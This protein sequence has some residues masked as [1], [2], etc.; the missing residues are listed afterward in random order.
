MASNEYPKAPGPDPNLDKFTEELAQAIGAAGVD[1]SEYDEW[2]EEQAKRLQEAQKDLFPGQKP[3]P[4]PKL[5]PDGSIASE[6]HAVGAGVDA[7]AALPK[8][9]VKKRKRK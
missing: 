5:N 2:R 4:L 8:K 6:S 3:F 9:P 7:P 1:S